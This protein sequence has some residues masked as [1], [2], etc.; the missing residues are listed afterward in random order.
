MSMVSRLRMSIRARQRTLRTLQMALTEDEARRI[1][2]NI[3]KLPSLLAK[4]E[5]R[6]EFV[7][8]RSTGHR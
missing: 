3:A 5:Q 8:P 7:P 2:S 6:M 1:A 4:H